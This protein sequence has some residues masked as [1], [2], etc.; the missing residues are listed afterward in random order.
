M[1]KIKIKNLN[2]S[3]RRLIYLALVGVFILCGGLYALFNKDENIPEVTYE[4]KTVV[5]ERP[6]TENPVVE[7]VPTPPVVETPKPT[8]QVAEPTSQW[9]VTYSTAEASSITVVVNKKHKL[10]STYAPAVVSV[11]SG[12]M[13]SEAATAMSQMLTD[14]E[15]AGV[16]MKIISSYRSY[17]TQVS[18]YQKWVNLQGQAEADR[19]SARPGH[20]EHQTGL[21]ADL[22]NPD[23]SCN[24]LACFGTGAQGI[25]LA[26]NAHNYGFI[27]RYPDGKESL[28]G[29]QYEPWH[30]RYV[31]TAEA[32]AIY[33]SGLTMDQYYGVEAGGY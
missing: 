4:L 19:G 15:N 30:V 24:L 32:T 27:I 33:Q 3:K 1:K 29:Y 31:G 10:P 21:A 20:S 18:T 17:N 13:R 28:T 16:G 25:W 14:A 6:A 22:G 2:F 26:S 12:Q 8:P 11:S 23:G 9:P 7:P 5:E